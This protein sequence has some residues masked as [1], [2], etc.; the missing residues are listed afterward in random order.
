MMEM[1]GVLGIIGVLSIG[2]I[3]GFTK[4]M[5]RSR[6][7]K[8]AEQI[9]QIIAGAMQYEEGLIT[10]N[11]VSGAKK[12][13]STF[14]SLNIIPKEM[15]RPNDTTYFYDALNNQGYIYQITPSQYYVLMIDIKNKSFEQC[16]SLL[17]VAKVYHSFVP[18]VA[19]YKNNSATTAVKYGDR[20]CTAARESAG[21]CLQDMSV[22][23]MEKTCSQCRVSDNKECSLAIYLGSAVSGNTYFDNK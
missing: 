20:L 21:S 6:L 3:A 9:S 13:T 7:N 8:Q 16:K 18:R 12:V 10:N 14:Y 17:Q 2:T 22:V 5:H 23:Q 1:L 15:Q 19:V 4:A 11:K